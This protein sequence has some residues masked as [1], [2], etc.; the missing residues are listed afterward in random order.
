MP[1]LIAR[2]GYTLIEILVAL[3][4]LGIVSAGVYKV[5]VNNQRIY[6]AQTQRIDLQQNIRAAAAILPAEFRQLDA[7]EGD[8]TAMGPDSIRMR[9]IR[10]L[11]FLCAA[12]SLGGSVS[13]VDLTIRQTPIYGTRQ[14]FAAGDS[15]LVYWE[16]DPASRSDDTWLPALLQQAPGTGTCSD[17]TPAIVLQKLQPTWLASTKFNISGAIT[18][19]SPVLRFTSLLYR[20]YADASGTW[21][22]G[23]Q[24]LSS[25]G[26][27]QPLVG[28]L[29]GSNGVTFSYFDSAGVATTVPTQVAQIQIVLRARTALPV[30][31][32]TGPLAYKV[33]S[34]VTWVALRNNPRCGPGSLPPRAC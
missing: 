9:A 18:N 24:N 1:L 26:S 5:L 14:T 29:I 30:R 11:A 21:W 31:D 33:D 19:G 3:V 20:S 28:P 8:I 13:Q 4:L 22:L 15:L 17:G 12:P 10:Q 34:T 23:V 16:G 27:I 25:G 32:G 6:T 7:A 2:R